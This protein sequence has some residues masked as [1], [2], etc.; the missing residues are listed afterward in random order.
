MMVAIRVMIRFRVAISVTVVTLLET[1]GRIERPPNRLE[2]L[3]PFA[4]AQG[5][6]RDERG[7]R[8]PSGEMEQS[9]HRS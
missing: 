3:L 8:S 6:T 7:R 5:D 4:A 9:G 2:C 1:K